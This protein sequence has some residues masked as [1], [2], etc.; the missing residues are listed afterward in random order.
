LIYTVGYA[1][2]KPLTLAVLAEQLGAVVT[3]CRAKPVS[4]NA[5]FNRKAL[6]ELLGPNYEWWGD[7]LG[8]FGG[9]SEAG[10]LELRQA[11]HEEDRLLICVEEHPEEC[12]RHGLICG[13]HFPEAIHIFRDYTFTAKDLSTAITTEAQELASYGDLSDLIG[14]HLTALLDTAA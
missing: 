7:R 9:T 12:H 4:R 5:G 3:D 14:S 10:I 6:T 8:G 13:P 11:A 2:L 1:R